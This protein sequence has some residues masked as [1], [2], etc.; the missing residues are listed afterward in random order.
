M[1]NK[2]WISLHRQMQDHW[3]WEDK[4][5]SKGQAWIDLLLS[6]N[7]KENETI[8]GNTLINVKKGSFITSEVKLA[9]KWGWSR[10]KVRAFLKLLE[11]E[12]MLVKESTTRYTTVTIENYSHYQDAGTTKEQQKNSEGTSRE[13]Q[14]NTNNNDNNDNNERISSTTSSFSETEFE[15]IVKLYSENIE[16]PNQLTGEWI[17]DMLKDYGFIWLKNAIIEANQA[18]KRFQ[19]YIEGILTNWKTNGGMKLS[20]DKSNK[21]S[22]YPSKVTKIQQ[23][24]EYD[25][26]FERMEKKANSYVWDEEAMEWI[27]K[28]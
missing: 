15:E 2:G 23:D 27:S 14:R 7:H 5:F 1:K 18:G 13:H 28:D 6:A 26:I 12:Q 22:S 19:K 10:K 16:L 4:P 21:V 9:D 11:S 17:M 25:E 20:K 24:E 8:I 3:L